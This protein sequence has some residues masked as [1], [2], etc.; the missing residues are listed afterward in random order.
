MSA[1]APPVESADGVRVVAGGRTLVSFAGCDSLGLARHPDVVAAAQE[2]LRRFGVGASASRTTSGTLAV[3]R[4][5]E[6]ALAD[7]AGTD[8]AVALP[9]GW[10]AGQA[11]A[12]ALA[13]SCDFVVLDDG[14]HPALEDAFRLTGLPGAR[15]AHFDA[16]AAVAAARGRGRVLFMTDAT[17]PARGTIAPL[18]ALSRAA[19]GCGGR[20]LADDAHGLGVL[21]AHGRGAVEATGAEGRHVHVAGSLSK[22]FGTQGGFVAG[23]RELCDAIRGRAAVYAGATPLAAPVAAAAAA[24]VRLAADPALRVRLARNTSRLALRLAPYGIPRPARGAPWFAI[25]GRTARSLAR[26]SA[27]LRAEGFLVPHLHYFGGPAPG[28]LKVAVSAAH[29]IEEIDALAD[30][31][32]RALGDVRTAPGPSAR[33]GARAARP[34]SRRR[35]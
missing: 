8:D 30:A 24:A 4:E 33:D 5:L 10:L 17:D 12:R 7:F 27:R 32:G 35:T 18:R 2:A 31:L 11:L 34:S 6:R 16:K 15:A 20:L 28:L 13:P 1:A 9:A 14:S 23:A 19:A 3:H 25:S 21:G 22:A 29:S 26:I